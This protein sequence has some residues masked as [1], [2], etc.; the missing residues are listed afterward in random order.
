MPL[1]AIT[2]LIEPPRVDVPRGAEGQ[3]GDEAAPFRELALALGRHTSAPVKL[4]YGF[5]RDA[6]AGMLLVVSSGYQQMM[7]EIPERDRAAVAARAILLDVDRSSILRWLETFRFA[8]AVEKHRWFEWVMRRGEET[9]GGL[10]GRRDLAAAI[11]GTCAG[12]GPFV[13]DHYCLLRSDRYTDLPSL[14]VGYL[15]AVAAGGAP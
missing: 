10:H 9:G 6:P 1:G 15:A 12:S 2:I 3:W 7:D 5:L 11:G 8:G 13:S 4:V 14:L